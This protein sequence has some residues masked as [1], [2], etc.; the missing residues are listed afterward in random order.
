[1]DVDGFS[2][3]KPKEDHWH[4]HAKVSGMKGRTDEVPLKSETGAVLHISLAL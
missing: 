3:R 1:L 2:T 4:F